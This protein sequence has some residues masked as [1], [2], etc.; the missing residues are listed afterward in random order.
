M[1]ALCDTKDQAL[2]MEARLIL[3]SNRSKLLN[4]KV[5]WHFCDEPAT[6]SSGRTF[7]RKKGEPVC[8]HTRRY[9]NAMANKYYWLRKAANSGS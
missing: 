9:I 6:A 4:D 7:H 8:E 2:Q 3:A 1:L 5:P